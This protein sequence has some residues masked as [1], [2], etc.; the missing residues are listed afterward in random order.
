[1]ARFTPTHGMRNTP[2]YQIWRGLK[3]RCMLPTDP[4]YERYGGRGIRVCDRWLIFE[5]FIEDVGRRPSPL[6][7]IDRFPDPDG[8][9]EPTNVR[10]ATDEQQNRNRGTYNVLV[11]LAGDMVTVAEFCNKTGMPRSVIYQRV[12][13]GWPPE[14]AVSQRI[15]GP[16]RNKRTVSDDARKRISEAQR[17]RWQH[18]RL[19]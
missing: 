18:V 13:A 12:S 9:Y 10:W 7:S 15:R 5:L 17:K 6:Y 16:L 4:A 1:M 11:P 3:S 19:S 14:D 8:D 2:E